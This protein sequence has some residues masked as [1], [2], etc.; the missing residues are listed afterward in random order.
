MSCVKTN[1][2]VTI[3]TSHYQHYGGNVIMRGHK[4]DGKRTHKKALCVITL[5][6]NDTLSLHMMLR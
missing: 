6:D 5:R 1:K 4:E 3:I 2:Y